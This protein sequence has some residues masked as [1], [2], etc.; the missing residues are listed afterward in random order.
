MEYGHYAFHALTSAARL[1]EEGEAL[2]HCVAIFAEDCTA[3]LLRIFSVRERKTG[4]RVATL[5]LALADGGGGRWQWECDQIQGPGNSEVPARM[6]EAADAVLRSF[7]DLP[8]STFRIRQ[9]S[10]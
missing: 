2:R 6:V 1:E 10:Q 3:G 8:R 4:L 7:E 5:A 9:K